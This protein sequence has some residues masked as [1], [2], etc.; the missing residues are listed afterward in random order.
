[1]HLQN[2]MLCFESKRRTTCNKSVGA[3][4]VIVTQQACQHI[5]HD[6]EVIYLCFIVSRKIFIRWYVL[7]ALKKSLQT[8]S[9]QIYSMISYQIA[10]KFELQQLHGQY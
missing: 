9:D 1:M 3:G 10:Y 2:F 6:Y 8:L 5:L 4:A 7:T